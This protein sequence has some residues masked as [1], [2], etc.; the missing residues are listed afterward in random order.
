MHTTKPTR[1]LVVASLCAAAVLAA[2]PGANASPKLQIGL[3]DTTE[4]LN[5]NP[6]RVFPVLKQ[7]GVQVLR[8]NLSWGGRLGVATNRPGDPTNPADPAY[9]WS[10]YDRAVNYAA[11]YGIRILFTIDFTPRWAN[12]GAGENV[13]PRDA[14]D[15]RDFAHAAATR[16]SGTYPGADGRAL[17]PVRM[18]TAWNEPNNPVF[19]SPQFTRVGR[20][21]VIQSARDYA[22]I[23]TAVYDGVHSTELRSERVACGATAPRGNN[24]PL[25]A[26]PSVSPIA[27]VRALKAAGLDR[28]DAYDHHP[29]GRGE[30]PG[31]PPAG[32]SQISLANIDD[33]TDEV[34]RLWGPKRLWIGEYGYETNPPDNS[35]GVS[36]K[37]Q[38]E[39]VTQAFGLA[40]ANPNVDLMIWFLLRDERKPA[41]WQSGFL[42]ATGRP[43][44]AFAA[45]QR[46]HG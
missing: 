33:L 2:S 24:S 5:G 41:G 7:L 13:A 16:Y 42:T 19:L 8:V 36:P 43:K 44:P 15:L 28:F 35:F 10:V 30:A 14:N 21:W 26:R 6:G 23:C 46:L 25:G 11:Q 22:R 3:V 20:R 12:G 9:D 1:A 4:T 34:A 40:R 31:A 17:P 45:F 18:W 32:R 27:F 39:Y 38:A 37:L 29:Y